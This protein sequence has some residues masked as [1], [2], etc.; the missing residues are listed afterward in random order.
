MSLLD[1]FNYHQAAPYTNYGA[2]DP[3]ETHEDPVVP[4]PCFPLLVLFLLTW[5]RWFVVCFP[6]SS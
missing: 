5:F 3:V 4:C 2:S 6:P 1:D